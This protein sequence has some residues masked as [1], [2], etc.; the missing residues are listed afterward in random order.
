M[1]DVS[2]FL[3]SGCQATIGHCR[4]LSI[5]FLHVESDNALPYPLMNRLRPNH[6]ARRSIVLAEEFVRIEFLTYK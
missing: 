2:A 3:G 1:N 5:Y 4:I 6:V